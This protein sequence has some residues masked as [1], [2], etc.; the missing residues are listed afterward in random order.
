MTWVSRRPSSALGE[1]CLRMSFPFSLVLHTH[2]PMVVN[3]GRWPHGCD[4]LNEATFE[5]YLPLL[6][7]A[8]RLVAE[9]IS[10]KWTVNLSPVLAE[11]LA[12]PEFQKE[13]VVLLREC[14]ARVRGEPR[15]LPARRST[16][17]RGA[18]V[19]LGRILRAHVGAAPAN[20]RRYP[21]HVRRAAAGRPS[22]DH[23]VR[24]HP[25]LPAAAVD[26]TSPSTCSCGRRSR[27]TSVTSAR[28]RGG[29][30]CRSAPTARAMNGRRRPAPT[31]V[32]TGRSGPASRRCWPR[33]ASSTSSP[34]RTWSP[35][36]SRSSSIATTSRCASRSAT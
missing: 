27:R 35:P 4:W 22:G 3:H 29:S 9:G 33:T 25:R 11:Q 24:G 36:A 1:R 10:P 28:R 18:D 20:R 2:L 5:C 26:A 32:A 19:L 8:H 31:A 17:D 16:G 30:G 7:T 14:S 12:S 6:E 21:G 23:H 34:T 13:L 15:A